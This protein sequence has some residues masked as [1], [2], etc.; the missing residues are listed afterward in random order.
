MKD[1]EANSIRGCLCV[2]YPSLYR[3]GLSPLSS[4]A[5]LLTFESLCSDLFTLFH[6]ILI[7]FAYVKS[8]VL[9]MLLILTYAVIVNWPSYP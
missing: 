3:L 9:I 5:R 6:V 1:L 4:T 7:S 2:V 8:S